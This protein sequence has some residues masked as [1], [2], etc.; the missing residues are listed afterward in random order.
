MKQQLEEY[1][2][3][4]QQELAGKNQELSELQRSGQDGATE[5][6]RLTD[7]RVMLEN[8]IQK[9]ERVVEDEFISDLIERSFFGFDLRLKGEARV[10]STF[11]ERASQLGESKGSVSRPLNDHHVVNLTYAHAV[12]R[13]EIE[14]LIFELGLEVIEFKSVRGINF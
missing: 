4:L 13:D 9:L 8:K 1:I 12:P 5:V 2:T 3:K 14:R 11:L 7:E 6:K 10:I